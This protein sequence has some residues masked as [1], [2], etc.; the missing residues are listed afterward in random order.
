MVERCDDDVF[1]G[2]A[3]LLPHIGGLLLLQSGKGSLMTTFAAR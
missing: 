2:R 3:D 1:C